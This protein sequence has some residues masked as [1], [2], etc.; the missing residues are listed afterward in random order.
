[1]DIPT[2]FRKGY[3]FR[4]GGM[5]RNKRS[6]TW[7]EQ[8]KPRRLFIRCPHCHQILDITQYDFLDSANA[9]Y[10]VKYATS[11][12]HCPCGH[13]FNFALLDYG[14]PDPEAARLIPLVQQ[15][16]AK[17]GES[18]NYPFY[19]LFKIINGMTAN[20]TISILDSGRMASIYRSNSGVY[21]LGATG[22]KTGMM[23]TT[24]DL[25]IEGAALA[26]TGKL[27]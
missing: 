24:V 25:A 2:L 18:D 5:T 4:R 16:M 9:K 21:S 12:S 14:K 19:S 7:T 22:L 1:M 23:F 26:L 11:C 3:I 10:T 15:Q 13:V 6:G 27:K 8:K 17:A 20:V